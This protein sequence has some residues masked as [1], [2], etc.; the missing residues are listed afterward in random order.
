[1]Q[2]QWH[3]IGI[4]GIC[5]C[6]CTCGYRYSIFFKKKNQSSQEVKMKHSNSQTAGVLD[7]KYNTPEL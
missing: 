2:Q 7:E 6:E 3:C 1:M 4:I 5:A